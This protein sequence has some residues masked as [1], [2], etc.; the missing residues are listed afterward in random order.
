MQNL[1]PAKQPMLASIAA[2]LTLLLMLSG[3]VVTQN[4]PAPGCIKSIGLPMSGGCFGKTAI[5]DLSVKA[6]SPCLD[7]TANNCNG[8]VLEV[9]NTCSETLTLGGVDI[10][11]SDYVSLDL[12][13][14]S[15]GTYALKEISSNFS[16]YSPPEDQRITI[17]GRMGSQDVTVTFT[18]TARLCE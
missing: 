2:L 6:E 12:V 4:S 15:P 11:P 8:G 18:K 3:C 13:E 1:Q 7:I 9:D 14:E 5:L 10:L 16:D 17:T